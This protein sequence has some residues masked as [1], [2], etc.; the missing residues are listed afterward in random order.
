MA[1]PVK[2]L[3]AIETDGTEAFDYVQSFDSIQQS[4]NEPMGPLRAA[5]LVADIIFPRDV[6]LYDVLA[7]CSSI[8]EHPQAGRYT[9]QQ[10]NCYFFCWA[11]ILLLSRRSGNWE[12]AAM[13]QIDNIQSA[14]LQALV[15]PVSAKNVKLA[16]TLSA[17]YCSGL[18][19][20]HLLL[21]NVLASELSSPQFSC[22]VHRALSPVLWTHNVHAAVKHGLEDRS[23]PLTEST[24]ELLIG[25]LDVDPEAKMERSLRGEM[26]FGPGVDMKELE[27]AGDAIMVRAY[28]DILSTY[29]DKESQELRKKYENNRTRPESHRVAAYRNTQLAARRLFISLEAGWRVLPAGLFAAFYTAELHDRIAIPPPITFFRFKTCVSFSSDIDYGARGGLRPSE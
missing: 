1:D 17:A 16:R 14:I 13:Q 15:A 5:N 2:Q 8:A 6:D 19:P 18:D 9:L 23:Q 11:I 26:K 28:L 21:C 3:A 20:P 25:D 24:L 7:A 27:L 4:A 12:N 29:I 10:Y 22:S